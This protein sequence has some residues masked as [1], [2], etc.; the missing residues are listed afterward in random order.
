[1]QILEFENHPNYNCEIHTSNGQTYKIYANWLHNQQLD[2]WQGWECHAGATRLYVDKNLEVWSGECQNDHLGHAVTG[3]EILEKTT[4]E[5]SRCTG[6]TD[7]LVVEKKKVNH[8]SLS[9]V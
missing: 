1:M 7:D 6:C 5:R 8:N 9:K 2:H 3:F 4:C